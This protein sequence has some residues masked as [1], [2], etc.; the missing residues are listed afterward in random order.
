MSSRDR[1]TEHEL[2]IA[3]GRLGVSSP[4]AVEMLASKLEGRPTL[5]YAVIFEL[6]LLGVK[7]DAAVP[8]LSRE[9]QKKCFVDL[10]VDDDYGIFCGMLG[11]IGTP[12]AIHELRWLYRNNRLNHGELREA[13]GALTRLNALPDDDDSGEIPSGTIPDDFPPSDPDVTGETV[14]HAEGETGNGLP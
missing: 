10:G 13:V 3:L 14:P 4:R 7:A 9:V 2:V 11:K 12:Q 6:G 5:T 8:A 1:S